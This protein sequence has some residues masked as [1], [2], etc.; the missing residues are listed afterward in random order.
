MEEIHLDNEVYILLGSC[1]C[2]SLTILT[3]FHR[4]NLADYDH[5]W[6]PSI[7]KVLKHM[8][9]VN[10]LDYC[11]IVWSFYKGKEFGEKKDRIAVITPEFFEKD[12][13]LAFLF[14]ACLSFSRQREARIVSFLGDGIFTTTTI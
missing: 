8:G 1:Q 4:Q 12:H 10:E 11:C 2:G 14:D 7:S 13:M 9:V 5:D 6:T 3:F